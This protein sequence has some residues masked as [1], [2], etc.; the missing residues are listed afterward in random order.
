MIKRLNIYFKEMYP[1]VPRLLLGLLLFFEVNFLVILTNNQNHFKIGIEEIIGSITIFFFFLFLRIADDF[2]DREVDK[3]LFP[4]RPLPSEKV[5]ANDLVVLL[6]SIITITIAINIIFMNNL[7]YFI[8]LA[9]YGMLMSFWFFKKKT[10]QKSLPLALITHNPVQLFLNLYIISFTC[11]KYDMTIFTLNNMII[12]FTLYWPG[13]I[14]EVSRKVRAPKEETEY[15]TYSKLFGYK[16]ATKFILVVMFFDMITSS[17]L[18][19]SLFPWAI[20]TVVV[21]YIWLIWKCRQF[22][23]DPYRFKLVEKVELYEYIAE[24]TILLLEIIF[25]VTMVI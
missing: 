9:C 8:I 22:M 24:G 6:T 25:I 5:K 1:I 20:I 23:D 19:Y 14:W 11:L 18:V 4:N 10:I 3:K 7:L 13:L 17:I 16:K 12:L 15:T 21:S 2:K